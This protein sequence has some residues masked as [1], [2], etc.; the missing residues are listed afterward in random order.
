MSR[1]QSTLQWTP[2]TL[3]DASGAAQWKANAGE[4]VTTD[5]IAHVT[6]L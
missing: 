4:G 6:A 2:Q 3:R 5:S 1:S